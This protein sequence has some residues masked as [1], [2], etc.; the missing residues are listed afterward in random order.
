VNRTGTTTRD[1]TGR[2]RRSAQNRSQAAVTPLVRP[3]RVRPHHRHRRAIRLAAAVL[4]FAAV[5]WLLLVSPVLG[6]QTVQVDGVTTLPAD[7]VRE[8]AGIEAGTPLLR[9]DVDAARARI[10]RLPQ[11]ASVEVTRGWP[12]TI[13]VTVVERV[14]IVVVGV[15]GQRFLVDA[16]G[17]LFDTVSGEPPAGVVPLDVA[18]P[19][20]GDPATMAA[21]AAIAALPAGIRSEV[22]GAAATSAEDVSLTLVDGTLVRWG[23]PEESDRKGVALAAIVEQLADGDLEAA[24]TIDVSTPEAVVLR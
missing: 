23:G 4:A 8:T 11:V 12:Q 10:A 22:A 16:E 3:R 2:S 19:G 1:R 15:P 6:V 7:Q 18:Q 14:P 20:P 21:L 24:G 17:V 13:V 5:L 9:V